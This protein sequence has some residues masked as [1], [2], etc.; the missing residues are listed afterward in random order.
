MIKK[1]PNTIKKAQKE[2]KKN[3]SNTRALLQLAQ[4]FDAQ[5]N[6][7]QA[8]K[9]YAQILEIN[10][11]AYNVHYQVGNLFL[12][13]G[14]FKKAITYYQHSISINNNYVVAYLNLGL[15][16]TKLGEHNSAIEIFLLALD[17]EPTN[18]L[19]LN[20]IAYTL[21]HIKKYQDSILPY[22]EAIKIN[23]NYIEAYNGLAKS[24][25][26]LGLFNDALDCYEQIM[27]KEPSYSIA[28][29]NAMLVLVQLQKNDHIT[30]LPLLK[31]DKMHD[32]YLLI[33]SFIEKDFKTTDIL[34]KKIDK[35]HLP[36][37]TIMDTK[38]ADA[39][40]LFIKAL[41]PF[42]RNQSYK[43]DP[44]SIYHIGESHSLSFAHQ[45]IYI[46][47]KQYY[48][49]PLTIFGAKAWHLD[50]N[51]TNIYKHYFSYHLSKL[52]EN[53][54]VLLSF[55][56]IDTRIDE[57]IL[58]FY[59]KSNEN[60]SNIIMNTIKNY[61]EYTGSLLQKKSINFSYLGIAAPI[62][63]KVND[64]KNKLRIEIIKEFNFL[65]KKECN[66]RSLNFTDIYEL[67]KNDMNVSNQKYMSDNY[68][69][70][71]KILE[72]LSFNFQHP[73]G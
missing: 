61:L 23:P 68:H 58:P 16:L 73:K 55:G 9:F 59:L 5:K 22:K 21:Q 60:L 56:E 62:I 2:I 8:L 35:E 3:P 11:Q 48:I 45:N 44:D 18:V 54:Y 72:V 26:E 15:S 53:T 64:E 7:S 36:C 31:Q 6:H 27:H 17:K 71:P 42:Q 63:K 34:L 41:L 32:I 13:L 67:T 66:Q 57:G 39:Y 24:Y 65:L 50:N 10:P 28:I 30:N 70:S 20:N 38:F 1:Y 43:T 25:L 69:L 29:T 47:D 4:Y 12:H 19:A 51:K 52:K 49:K 40:S 37:N 33:H 14:E 46:Q